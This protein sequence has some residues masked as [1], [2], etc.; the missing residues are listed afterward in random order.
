MHILKASFLNIAGRFF[1]IL[2]SFLCIFLLGRMYTA[3]DFG[4]WTWLFSIFSLV[5]AQ[6][7]G[8]IGAMRVRLGQ[9]I[10]DG[11]STEQKL[12]FS[13]AFLI[14]AFAGLCIIGAGVF[15]FGSFSQKTYDIILV[16]GCSLFTVLGYC[17]AQGSVA[18]LQSGWIGISE[19]LRG[20]LQIFVIA[21]SMLYDLSFDV[22]LLA[23]Y[24][25]SS[26]YTP[27][28]T[29]VFLK[30]RDWRL[31]E[32]VRVVKT[33]LPTCVQISKKLLKEGSYL[34]LMQIGLALLTLSDV[35]IAGFLVSDDEVAILNALVRLVSVA[36]GFVVASM[37]P[38]MGYF[39]AQLKT[40]NQQ[41]IWNRFSIAAVILL[42]TGVSYGVFLYFFGSPIIHWWANLIVAPSYVFIISGVL[43]SAL[44]IVILLQT[45]LQMPIVTKAMLP[46]LL[47]AG[48][49]KLFLPFVIVPV[50]GYGGV[51]VSG[52]IVNLMFV[53]VAIVLLFNRGYLTKIFLK[54][55]V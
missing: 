9:A 8:F 10:I 7:F 54:P 26:L 44:G 18:Y 49:F 21:C 48:M 41:L 2:S 16:L 19:S 45:F 13:V 50:M 34:W 1:S 23:F 46:L 55:F 28:V 51:L 31:Q 25:V 39:V 38:V 4:Y 20:I 22:S 43:F 27:F 47:I 29:F 12:I 5:T 42:L 6:D 35:F 52:V 11:E 30:S 3:S 32:L 36:V 53:L 37:T 33:N 14:S 40:L 24:L 15:L 17:A